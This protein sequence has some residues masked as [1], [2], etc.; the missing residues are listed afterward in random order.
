VKSSGVYNRV[1][2]EGRSW[3]D[4]SFWYA[5]IVTMLL[6]TPFNT[7]F[8][9]ND[10][11]NALEAI[12]LLTLET[13]SSDRVARYDDGVF[14]DSSSTN[15]PNGGGDSA[16]ATQPLVD[17]PK[18]KCEMDQSVGVVGSDPLI[19]FSVENAVNVGFV[20]DSIGAF[21]RGGG[22]GSARGTKCGRIS[23]PERLILSLGP[24]FDLD[25][26]GDLDTAVIRTRLDMEFKGNAVSVVTAKFAGTITGQYY[27]QTGDNS[28]APPPSGLIPTAFQIPCGATGSDSNNDSGPNDNCAIEFPFDYGE[29][30]EAP[31][32]IWDSLEFDTLVGDVSLE[33]GGDHGSASYANRSEFELARLDGVLD[34]QDT[35]SANEGTLDGA[36]LSNTDGDCGD[37]VPYSLEFDGEVFELL[38][39]PAGQ[40]LTWVVAAEWT[41][42]DVTFPIPPTRFTWDQGEVDW[43]TCDESSDPNC[44]E[45]ALCE[46]TPQRF[47]NDDSTQS[48][49]IDDDCVA[50][51]AGDTCVL[52]DYIPP[53]GGFPDM[54]PGRPG[55]NYACICDETT[56]DLG[57]NGRNG[58]DDGGY[59]SGDDTEAEELLVQQ[60]IYIEGDARGSRR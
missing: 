4:D 27:I 18:N 44:F 21:S 24:G 60:C 11:G 26:D 57:L 25:D 45:L 1:V 6:L 10:D 42:E 5:A 2:S 50:A 16:D 52:T 8:S 7:A 30:G 48:C 9:G 17:E 39:Q 58:A 33:G 22:G 28:D 13:G 15:P 31:A 40:D 38:W 41:T 54:D 37:L 12:G 55:P 59:P 35:F 32:A 23:D 46:G 34:C 36:R 29:A 3:S 14:G 20:G 19:V 56:T 47:C 43:E 49:S 53:A 51:E